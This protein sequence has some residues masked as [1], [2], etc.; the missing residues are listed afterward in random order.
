M[1]GERLKAYGKFNKDGVF[2]RDA[3]F[4]EE[5]ITIMSEEIINGN[6]KFNENF[7]T[8]IGDIVRRFSQNYLGK[9]ITFDTGRDVYNFV[10]DY[11]KSIKDG[12]INPAILKVA[13]EGAK[14][15]LVEGKADPKAATQMSKATPLEAI[16]ELIPDNVK[17]Q[18]DYYA[19]LDDPKVTNR[20]LDTRGRLA[21]VIENYIRSRST[22]PEMTQKNIE[23]VKDRLV[24]FDPAKER[25]DGSIV[26]PE[27][28]GE[29]IFAN[30]RFGKMV[31]AKK[32]AVESEKAKKT[33]AIDTKEAKEL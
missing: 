12:K 3:N 29:F 21:P 17:T 32:L 13:W 11:S 9:E 30:A 16:N 18:E 8:K 5:T 31:A 6:L 28:F 33:T 4:G 1:L 2:E 22:S 15:K 10:K 19:L 25:A 23:A 14:G 24:N 27:G 26:G 20:I 7:F